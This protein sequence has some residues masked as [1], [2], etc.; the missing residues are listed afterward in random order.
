MENQYI[1]LERKYKE[2]EIQNDNLDREIADLL[3]YCNVTEKQ[4]TTYVSSPEY[5]SES[6]W[7]TLKKERKRMDDALALKLSCIPNPA[8]KKKAQQER[9]VA[10]HWLFVR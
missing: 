10:P 1:E 2:L 5:F 8:K 7:E 3:D 9:Y 6:Q 4:L